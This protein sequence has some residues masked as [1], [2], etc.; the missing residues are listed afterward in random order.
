MSRFVYEDGIPDGIL[1]YLQEEEGK[2]YFIWEYYFAQITK[3]FP[4]FWDR[5]IQQLFDEHEIYVYSTEILKAEYVMESA[6]WETRVTADKLH[7]DLLIKVNGKDIYRIIYQI[8]PVEEN[9][10]YFYKMETWQTKSGNTGNPANDG[11]YSIQVPQQRVLQLEQSLQDNT[12]DKLK[13]E[14]LYFLIP[15]S[16]VLKFFSCDKE[17]RTNKA[18][19]LEFVNEGMAALT[20]ENDFH[21][22]R[23]A[24]N[25]MIDIWNQLCKILFLQQKELLREIEEILDPFTT[26]KKRYFERKIREKLQTTFAIMQ[27]QKIENITEK[28]ILCER[29]SGTT[30]EACELKV[31]IIFD[32]SKEQAKDRVD[33]YWNI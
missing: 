6:R 28:M 3:E 25:I 19:W 23:Y 14:G 15:L 29:K 30:K 26:L 18:I 32:L 22:T 21:M 12:F 9:C 16:M 13:E 33:R 27:I 17:E 2:R 1:C 10:I 7:A 11:K 8:S 31:Q 5:I 24:A 4:S 20:D